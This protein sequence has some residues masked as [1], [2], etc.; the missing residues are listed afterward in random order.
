MV[1]QY[2]TTPVTNLSQD[3]IETWEEMKMLYPYLYT[4]SKNVLCFSHISPIGASFP[5]LEL[6]YLKN[7][8]DYWEKDYPNFYF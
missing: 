6:L 5:K 4:E 3:P 1:M 7:G 2:L 8:T